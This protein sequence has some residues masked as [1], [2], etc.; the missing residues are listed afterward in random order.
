M[1]NGAARWDIHTPGNPSI[2]NI[3]N[4]NWSD[5]FMSREIKFR[6]ESG[7]GFVYGL[8][9]YDEEGDVIM[10]TE[11]GFA[12]EIDEE[13]I[14]QYTGMSDKNQRQIYDGDIVTCDDYSEGAYLG[15]SQ[16]RNIQ[17]ISFDEK[18]GKY[19]LKGQGFMPSWSQVEI[20]G[21]IHQNP[22]LLDR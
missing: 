17:V 1:R 16:P 20:I 3:F 22:E 12:F 10:T 5:Y 19:D 18:Y 8:I 6:A 14:G 9:G 4:F 7:G 2:A 21:N 13:T 11:M 15:R